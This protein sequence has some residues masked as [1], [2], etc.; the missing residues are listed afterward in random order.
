MSQPESDATASGTPTVGVG[1]SSYAMTLAGLVLPMKW[2]VA[3][4]ALAAAC[5][6]MLGHPYVAAAAFV[7]YCA[8]D[9]VH[10]A[11]LARWTAEAATADE[12]AGLRKL[13]PLCAAR[14]GVYLA[15]V[16]FVALGGHPGELLLFG[17]Q[18]CM[19]L[20]LGLSAG[21]L[22]RWVFWG[23]AGPV[24]AACAS[25]AVATLTPL[26]GA[27]ALLGLAMLTL[28]LT[29]MTETTRGVILA[30]HSAFRAN[31][32]MIPELEAARDR[33]VAERTAAEEAREEARRAN[34]AKSNFL[35]TMSHEIRTPMNGVLGMAQ[36]LKRDE[37]DPRQG[38]RIDV[39]ID[40]GEYLLS[41]LNDILDISKI[42]AGH[43]K[44]VKGVEDLQLFLD[45]LVSFWGARADEKGVGLVLN[46]APSLPDF[47]R[48]DALRLRQILF[49]LVG[50]ALKFT[51]EGAI[52]I[53][54]DAR[55]KSKRSAWVHVAVRDSGVGIASA[56]LPMLFE[57]FSQA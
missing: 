46:L 51:D 21:V 55:P 12:E 54:A 36:L 14:V 10:R 20:A 7:A 32:A 53:T 13:A 56:H 25:L 31:L 24:L 33:A 49:N 29:A 41:I 40:S 44:I 50:N 3:A 19:M 9:L 16:T 47:V 2:H 28:L 30:W 15:P 4:N 17:I 6:L 22:S 18:A 35:A 27:G 52:E 38:E 39:L 26:A 8:I 37:A 34:R 48:M 42:D 23:F 11:F 57:R 5:L 45:R 43:L 1:S